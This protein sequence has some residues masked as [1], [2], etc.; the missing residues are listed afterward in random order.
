MELLFLLA[1]AWFFYAL[2][3]KNSNSETPSNKVNSKKYIEEKASYASS[4]SQGNR[5]SEHEIDRESNEEL[6]QH[7]INSKC[8]IKFKYVDQDGEITHRSVTPQ[9]IEIRHDNQIL[10][11]IGYCHL[12]NAMRTFI[13]RKMQKI[14]LI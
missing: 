1:L 8:D 7:A 5:Y 13:V 2:F 9:Y 14:T 6:I 3:K 11:L 4:K 10:C 12:R